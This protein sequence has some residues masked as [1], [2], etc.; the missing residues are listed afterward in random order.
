M[1]DYELMFILPPDLGEEG[2]AK[3]IKEVYKMITDEKG[4]VLNE[5]AW[6]VRD[7]AYRIEKQDEG[8][9]VVLVF[10][11]DP[12]KI[13][14]MERALILNQKILR[15]LITKTPEDYTLKTFKEYQKEW[16]LEDKREEAAKKEQEAKKKSGRKISPRKAAPVAVAKKAEKEDAAEEKVESGEKEETGEK[17]KETKKEEAEGGEKVKEEKE[18]PKKAPAKKEEK[19]EDTEPSSEI[20][21]KLKSI[22]DDPD[23]SL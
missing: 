11:I 19:K 9:Y 10:S 22:I 17:I 16:E 12:Q 23:I 20:D 2:V 3:E 8:F 21:D 14:E 1:K 18:T 13:G 15:F 5:D 6:G 4:E 7:L